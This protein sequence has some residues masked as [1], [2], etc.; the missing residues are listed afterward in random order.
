MDAGPDNP[1]FNS[2]PGKSTNQ[3]ENLQSKTAAMLDKEDTF[4]TYNSSTEFSSSE[5]EIHGFSTEETCDNHNNLLKRDFNEAVQTGACLRLYDA[6]VNRRKRLDSKSRGSSYIRKK[7][8]HSPAS[9]THAPRVQAKQQHSSPR[10]P[11]KCKSDEIQQHS[12]KADTTKSTKKDETNCFSTSYTIKK[13]HSVH[14]NIMTCNSQEQGVE[15]ALLSDD[16]E[17]SLLRVLVAHLSN[18]TTV[19]RETSQTSKSHEQEHEQKCLA[20]LEAQLISDTQR[21]L[22]KKLMNE[23]KHEESGQ[24]MY[25]RAVQSQTALQ[26]K[27]SMAAKK[28]DKML[29]EKRRTKHVNRHSERI[30]AR[31]VDHQSYDK[32]SRLSKLV[33][34]DAVDAMVGN[35]M[36]RINTLPEEYRAET[37]K[38]VLHDVL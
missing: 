27:I 12:N 13:V 3:K 2:T 19:K 35:L 25:E 9:K 24:R 20:D 28:E 14:K 11:T 6:A 26:K 8:I 29:R 18:T 30:L 37:L 17:K 34:S 23:K 4:S 16:I 38:R 15:V 1:Y 33:R 21:K 32:A 7:K 22:P 5:Q 10:P 31:K 36:E